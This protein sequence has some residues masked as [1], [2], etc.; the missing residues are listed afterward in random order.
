MQITQLPMKIF[1]YLTISFL[2]LSSPLYAQFAVV[3]DDGGFVNVYDGEK[4]EL[5]RLGVD[6][7]VSIKEIT[8][9]WALV[10]Y[11][12]YG[13]YATSSGYIKRGSLVEIASFEEIPLIIDSLCFVTLSSREITIRLE[14]EPFDSITN[15]IT[16]FPKSNDQISAINEDEYWGT[17]IGVPIK[18][19]RSI[20]CTKQNVQVDFPE[21]AL[22]NL[23]NPHL[24][25]SKAYYDK[26]K[27]IIYLLATN[28]D[29]SGAYT[30]VWM[31]ESGVYSV[32]YI[33]D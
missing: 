13:E 25:L 19:Y 9:E 28:G 24:S 18:E 3:V 5:D 27:D 12:K 8:Q 14:S 17:K 32:H 29:S 16:Y 15:L 33:F 30:V 22:F 21:S 1:I 26:T 11:T 23:F 31:I 20:S 4:E 7:V 10:D 6:E 2:F